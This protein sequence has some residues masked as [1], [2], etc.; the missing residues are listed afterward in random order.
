MTRYLNISSASSDQLL[1]FIGEQLEQQRLALN[2]SQAKAAS[3]AGV[4]R[5]TITRMEAGDTVSLDTFVRVLKV[6]G[7]VDR[8]AALFPDQSVRPLD[9]VKL[10]GKRRQR[11][12]SAKEAEAKTWSWG[13][14]PNE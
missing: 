5:R 1:A 14:E 12:S 8:L 6:Y 7:L 10:A 2:I 11:A 4:S 3:E 9:R 13:D